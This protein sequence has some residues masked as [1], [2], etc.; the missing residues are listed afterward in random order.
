M[1]RQHRRS[2]LP[3]APRH[4]SAAIYSDRW[5]LEKQ[6]TTQQLYELCNDLGGYA[7]AARELDC[8]ESTL[9]RLVHSNGE[10]RMQQHTASRVHTAMA[11]RDLGRMLRS[12]R[13]AN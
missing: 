12:D 5:N 13:G 4:P 10:H 7:A 2:K 3:N 11:G 6:I 8:N 1:A 9:R